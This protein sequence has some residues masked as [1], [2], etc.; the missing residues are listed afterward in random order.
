MIRVLIA[1][2]SQTTR[3]L[4]SQILKSAGDIEVVGHATTGQE[5]C[6]MTKELN[7]D[8]LLMDIYMPDI[9]GL[10]ATSKLMHEYP[11][12]IVLISGRRTGELVIE[13]LS[14]GALAVLEKP[15]ENET[16]HVSAMSMHLL[17]TVRV[18]SSMK[19]KQ[20]IRVLKPSVNQKQLSEITESS[21]LISKTPE[22]IKLTNRVVKP[23]I[24]AVAASVGGPGALE[25]IFRVLPSDFPLPIL[26]T[27]HISKGFVSHFTAWLNDLTPLNVKLAQ[28]KESLAPGTIYIAPD[29]CHMGLRSPGIMHL[30]SSPPIKGFQPS[31]TFMFQSVAKHYGSSALGIIL[32]GMGDDGVAGLVEIKKNGGL[33]IAQN[34]ATSIVFSMPGH[35]VEQNLPDYLLPIDR[36][37]QQ[38]MEC[39]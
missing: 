2:D 30:D 39:M 17:T 7:P 5:A 21:P 16:G 34:M 36:I 35:A 4:L 20:Q 15:K 37:A 25:I 28:D 32:T 6:R 14:R 13:A 1:D 24:V 19:L 27:Q 10:E 8:L 31:C 33:I 26:V 29:N 3:Q 11:L 12:P 18:I 23:A 22:N 9:D 38:L